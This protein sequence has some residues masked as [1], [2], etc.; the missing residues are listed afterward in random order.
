M[1]NFFGDSYF[2]VVDSDVSGHKCNTDIAGVGTNNSAGGGLRHRR[3]TI[4]PSGQV[5]SYYPGSP[6]T[7]E[8]LVL[9]GESS[10]MSNYVRRSV[11]SVLLHQRRSVDPKKH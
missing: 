8:E 10:S 2:Q 6:P 7:A 11:A 9:I 3:E 5:A 4:Y 1:P